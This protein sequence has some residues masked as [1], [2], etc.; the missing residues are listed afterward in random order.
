MASRGVIVTCLLACIATIVIGCQTSSQA[1]GEVRYLIGM[2]QA[3]LVE[4]WRV[5]MN[6]EIKSESQQYTE[7]NVLFED[8]AQSSEKQVKDVEK[9][10]A[11]GIDLLMISPNEVEAL[12]PIVNRAAEKIPVIVLDRDDPGYNYSLYI[13]PDNYAIGQQ[14][15][16]FV[17]SLLGKQGGNVIEIQGFSDSPPAVGRSKGFRE[18]L[19]EHDNIHI[20][21][22]IIADWMR[23]RA[24]DKVKEV[25]TRY[26][27]VDVIFAHNDAMAQGASIAAAKL[28]IQGI[29]FVGIDGLSGANGGI[30]LVR[31]GVLTGTFNY[32]TGGKVAVQ[33]AMKLLDHE[34][35][36]PRRVTLSSERITRSNFQDGSTP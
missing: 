17:V 13:G 27:K 8:A 35:G 14:A 34:K 30:Q 10:L 2:S 1:S 3:N 9:L 5:Q 32:P 18:V 12:K 4:P 21:D 29:Q 22:T 6:H 36:L 16:Q 33:Y 20:V 25:I 11:Q 24:E 26:P 23:D 28:R 31:M 19:S 15:G 7:M